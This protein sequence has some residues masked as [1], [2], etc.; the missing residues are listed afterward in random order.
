MILILTKYFLAILPLISTDT[1]SKPPKL[2]MTSFKYLPL[3]LPPLFSEAF[4]TPYQLILFVR[5]EV[6]T[7]LHYTGGY[8]ASP[9]Y[10]NL[11]MLILSQECALKFTA[12]LQPFLHDFNL[13][14]SVSLISV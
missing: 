5:L 12:H 11:L 7:S 8:S 14:G 6:P 3:V 1:L 9:K 13:S 10:Y 2:L 4:I